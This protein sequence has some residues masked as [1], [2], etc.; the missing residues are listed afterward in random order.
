[1]VSPPAPPPPAST[2]A[3]ATRPHGQHGAAMGSLLHGIAPA[4]TDWLL[5]DLAFTKS[6][7]PGTLP[8]LMLCTGS[9]VEVIQPCAST[10]IVP[11]VVASG[12]LPP[13]LATAAFAIPSTDVEDGD[14]HADWS[15][16]VKCAERQR[17][18]IAV[19]RAARHL[20][21]V[22][23]VTTLRRMTA[24]RAA[25][26]AASTPR[27][28]RLRGGGQE[29]LLRLLLGDDFREHAETVGGTE[30]WE[31]RVRCAVPLVS[32]KLQGWKRQLEA[33]DADK[34]H[35][36]RSQMAS[37]IILFKPQHGALVT[38]L[39]HVQQ[40]QAH[41]LQL[42]SADASSPAVGEAAATLADRAGSLCEYW[43]ISV[44]RG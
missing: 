20:A 3:V 1:M 36:V 12:P 5:R 19:Q 40:T 34:A 14:G 30:E 26:A 35:Q 22:R 42:L 41:I 11:P 24:A 32:K 31:R 8:W 27:A 29:E 39:H 2:L 9:Q 44:T 33:A 37:K 43:V 7:Q 28:S 17:A 25:R 10:P 13:H 16:A 6:A 38:Q 21:A 18:A 23:A 4:T 15:A